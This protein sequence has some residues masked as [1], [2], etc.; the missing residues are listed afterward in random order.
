MHGR[1]KP[2]LFRI[3]GIVVGHLGEH[4][5][6]RVGRAAVDDVAH[7]RAGCC[8]RSCDLDLLRAGE[9]A[10]AGEEG[11]AGVGQVVLVDPVQPLHVR[12]APALDLGPR[13]LDL[14]L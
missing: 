1:V 10:V 9:L 14:V 6:G 12:V 2:Y 5:I 11:D 13:E 8:G 4:V 3:V 7:R